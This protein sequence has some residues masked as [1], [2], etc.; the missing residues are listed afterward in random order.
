MILSARQ[1]KAGSFPA[2]AIGDHFAG[3]AP[4]QNGAPPFSG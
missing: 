1:A 4:C 3:V 2:R